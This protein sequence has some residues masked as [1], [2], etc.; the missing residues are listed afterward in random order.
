MSLPRFSEVNS[1]IVASCFEQ[2]KQMN[3]TE[4][5]IPNTIFVCHESIPVDFRRDVIAEV[6]NKPLS[7][8]W[9]CSATLK[10]TLR[11]CQQSLN[12]RVGRL[13]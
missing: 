11:R 3:A 5:L 9:L 4:I 10:L 7:L 1:L 12:S 2:L 8:H 13:M 6:R